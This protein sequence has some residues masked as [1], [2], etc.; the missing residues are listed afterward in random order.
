RLLFVQDVYNKSSSL[1]DQGEEPSERTLE[2]KDFCLESRI[3]EVM[4]VGKHDHVIVDAFHTLAQAIERNHN[5][6]SGVNKSP[7]LKGPYNLVGTQNWLRKIK[8]IFRTMACID[9][10]KVTLHTFMIVKDTEYCGKNIINIWELRLEQSLSKR[11]A[12]RR[13]GV[14][15]LKEGNMIAADYATKFEE[16]L[17]YLLYHKNEVEE[18]SNYMKSKGCVHYKSVD[19]MKDD[20]NCDKEK[21]TTSQPVNDSS[22]ER[23][24]FTL[25]M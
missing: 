19:P 6:D 23:M 12:W 9:I 17:R 14:L 7:T 4:V 3:Q 2:Q 10:Q 15:E 24:L 18:P 22:K 11:H 5:K 21:T 16:L 20:N 13:D 1:E 25:E 8:K